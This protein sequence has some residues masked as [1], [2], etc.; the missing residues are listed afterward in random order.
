MCTSGEPCQANAHRD[1]SG[2]CVCSEGFNLYGT[3]C[4]RC[5]PGSLWSS[6]ANRCIYVCGQN[7]AFSASAGKCVCNPGFGLLNKVCQKCPSNYFIKDGFCVTCPLHSKY[8]QDT[9]TCKCVD[10]FYTD[11]FGVCVQK[12]GQNENYN[13]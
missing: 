5:P 8:H 9:K 11:R 4:S 2:K 12:C 13:Q 3:V 7:S 10:G 6:S 1:A